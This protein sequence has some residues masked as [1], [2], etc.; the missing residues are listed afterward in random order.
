MSD[1]T[2]AKPAMT[3]TINGRNFV[4]TENTKELPNLRSH[5]IP[6]GFDGSVWYGF[7]ARNARQRKDLY[8]LVYRTQD[9]R[10]IIATTV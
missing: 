10:F 6:Q 5:I 8:S 3:T 4:L 7:S 9:G 2:S 1:H